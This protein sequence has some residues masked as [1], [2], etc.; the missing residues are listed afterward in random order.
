MNKR[1][2][3][4]AV[5]AALGLVV[6]LAIPRLGEQGRIRRR[7]SELAESVSG[8]RRPQGA[9][10]LAHLARVGNFFT[11]DV[12][13]KVGD[14][15]PELRG[16]EQVVGLAQRA[17]QHA[18]NVKVTFADIAVRLE[19]DERRAQVTATVLVTGASSAEAESVNARELEIDLVK[20]DGDWLIEAVRPVAVFEL[21]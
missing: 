11:E 1:A 17:L 2:A 4:I 6:W 15:V 14:V 5:V 20:P 13:I 7:L 16:R 19:D 8:G 18:V 21:D 3:L 12:S 10:L 9:A